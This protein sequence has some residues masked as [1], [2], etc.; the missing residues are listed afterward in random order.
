[1]DDAGAPAPGAETPEQQQQQLPPPPAELFAAG[2]PEAAAAG[3]CVEARPLLPPDPSRATPPPADP[4]GTPGERLC[5]EAQMESDGDGADAGR[6]GCGW[7]QD[8]LMR[9]VVGLVLGIVVI[10]VAAFV[11]QH[12][13]AKPIERAGRV[14]VREVGLSGMALFVFLL[15][16]APQPVSF[17][18]LLYVAIEGGEPP[19][20]VG[21]WLGSWIGLPARAE[22]WLQVK[23]PAVREALVTRGHCGAAV[24]ALLPVPFALATWPAGA[25]QLQYCPG[26]L[27]VTTLRGVK[28]AVYAFT[29]AAAVGNTAEQGP[30][31]APAVAPAAA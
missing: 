12:F 5:A 24:V 21:Y 23:Y 25:L 28:V 29:I 20:N 4:H 30:V 27:A 16:V 1:M 31:P 3:G 9:M 2:A 6:W 7:S 26:F 19:G 17:V 8:P 14:V 10:A 18:P 13:F 11:A 15:D 22:R